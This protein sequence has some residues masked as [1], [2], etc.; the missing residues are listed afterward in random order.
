MAKMIA[1]RSLQACFL[2]VSPPFKQEFRFRRHKKFFVTRG[3][4]TRRFATKETGHSHLINI[5]R[6]R[7]NTREH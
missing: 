2:R 4:A 1:K 3:H 5:F 7:K 6:Q